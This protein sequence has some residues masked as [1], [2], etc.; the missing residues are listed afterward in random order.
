[1][2]AVSHAFGREEE[3]TVLDDYEAVLCEYIF[4]LNIYGEICGIWEIFPRFLKSVI[5]IPEARHLGMA[6]LL[7]NTILL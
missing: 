1:M 4:F 3:G 6:S 2:H 5:H 7:C